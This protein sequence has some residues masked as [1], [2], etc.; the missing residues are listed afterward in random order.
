MEPLAQHHEPRAEG[1]P[2]S[3][4]LASREN[5]GPSR[6]RGSWQCRAPEGPPQQLP[7]PVRCIPSSE[8]TGVFPSIVKPFQRPNKQTYF[9]RSTREHSSATS[10]KT[11]HE[12]TMRPRNRPPG[13]APGGNENLGSHKALDANVPGGLARHSH[14]PAPRLEEPRPTR[15]ASRMRLRE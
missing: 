8:G 9:A 2:L 5:S 1:S 4:L 11:K 6:K 10:F 3:R 12:T 13:H 14:R 7:R 15:V